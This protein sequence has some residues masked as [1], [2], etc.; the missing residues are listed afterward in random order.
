MNALRHFPPALH[1]L[2]RMRVEELR[3]LCPLPELMARMGYARFALPS[4]RSPFRPDTKPSWGIFNRNGRWGWKD[5]GSQQGGDEINFIIAAGEATGKPVTSFPGALDIWTQIALTPTVPTA[6]T[7]RPAVVAQGPP[8]RTGFGPGSDAQLERLARLRDIDTRAIVHASQ[9][10]VLVFGQFSGH[11]VFGVTDSSGHVLE[12]RRLD[13]RMF[14]AQGILNERKSH[15]LRGS[16]KNWPVGIREVGPKPTILLVEGMPDF[17]A[18]FEVI[19][20]EDALREAAPV[21]M[22]SASCHIGSDALPLFNGHHV[23]IVPHADGPGLEA[24]RRWITQLA[25]CEGTTANFA[26]LGQSALPE[27]RMVKDLNEY[28]PTHRADLLAGTPGGRLL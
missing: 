6:R 1:P 9:L 25:T 28:L 12:V 26:L 3:A 8:D 5:H 16:R 27:A 7:I 17:L 4:C 21:A 18:A 2:P 23:R 15:A 13:G 14:P 10:G 19:I 11:E 20:T 22:L 24:A